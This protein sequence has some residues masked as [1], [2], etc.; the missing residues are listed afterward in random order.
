MA[1]EISYKVL[2]TLLPNGKVRWL[3][4]LTRFRT[5]EGRPI[6]VGPMPGSDRYEVPAYA[7]DKGLITVPIDWNATKFF[8]LRYPYQMGLKGGLFER[9]GHK[10]QVVSNEI[11]SVAV[12][13]PD[14]F[15]AYKAKVMR[16]YPIPADYFSAVTEARQI[17]STK[18]GK[19][20]KTMIDKGDGVQFE[21]PNAKG[22]DG[23][24]PSMFGK[25][26]DLSELIG[27]YV[28]GAIDKV[29]GFF[30]MDKI[31]QSIKDTV[32]KLEGKYPMLATTAIVA[33]A[34]IMV[35]DDV[36]YYIRFLNDRNDQDKF[37]ANVFRRVGININEQFSNDL[38]F[39]DS[40][41]EE[42]GRDSTLMSVT[43]GLNPFNR[44]EFRIR[45]IKNGISEPQIE[46]LSRLFRESIAILAD[47]DMV[48]EVLKILYASSPIRGGQQEMDEPL[49]ASFFAPITRS[50]S[51]IYLKPPMNLSVA[52][53]YALVAAAE[54]LKDRD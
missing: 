41:G 19:G 20:G 32:G 26:L 25:I 29:E 49:N 45:G 34:V 42:F 46:T 14:E 28:G 24:D 37:N 33:M 51:N 54:E 30:D 52:D 18:T 8:T 17:T 38:N 12:L 48:D 53:I 15:E 47:A 16:Y 13:R 2:K 44:G 39:I 4:V 5:K 6:I 23:K 50:L 7:V 10:I 11:H 1:A 40:L 35:M 36:I 3:P 21:A 27:D 31:K 9:V 43:Q 22:Y